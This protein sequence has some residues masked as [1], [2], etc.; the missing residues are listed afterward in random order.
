LMPA[1]PGK[2]QSA[3]QVAAKSPRRGAARRCA[4]AFGLVPRRC[5]NQRPL[6]ATRGDRSNLF[7]PLGLWLLAANPN[8]TFPQIL[9]PSICPGAVHR[10]PQGFTMGGPASHVS[11]NDINL[12]SS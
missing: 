5:F 11:V 6:K 3:E 7:L 8:F 10:R 2:H 12:G 9:K 1:K 4:A